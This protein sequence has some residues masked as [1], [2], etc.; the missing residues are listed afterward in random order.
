MAKVR[1]RTVK[2]GTKR[3]GA[4]KRGGVRSAKLK[5][6]KVKR[7]KAPRTKPRKKGVVGTMRAMVDAV[8]EAKALRTRLTGPDTF[9]DR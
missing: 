6:R 8:G 3:R 4:A 7:S 9:E 1:A 5:G 2:R